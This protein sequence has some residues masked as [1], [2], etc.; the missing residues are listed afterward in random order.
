MATHAYRTRTPAANPRLLR[1]GDAPG[2][3]LS[4]A[5]VLAL[6]GQ[7][8]EA[9]PPLLPADVA[10]WDGAPLL[11]I[12][13][14]PSLKTA[15]NRRKAIFGAVA[16]AAVPVGVL[17]GA[18]AGKSETI[19]NL[20]VPGSDVRLADH[21]QRFHDIEAEISALCEAH[22]G[23]DCDAMPGWSKLEGRRSVLL[24]QITETPAVTL[25]GIAAKARVL[26]V[27]TVEAEYQWIDVLSASIADDVLRLHGGARV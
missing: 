19:S 6:V 26:Q 4:E 10:P 12:A 18:A 17:P 24:Y 2:R 23:V 8:P 22:T 11:P 7:E 25:A 21:C 5:E 16:L 27:D 3:L 14:L 1:G 15:F 9:A 13:P 20:P